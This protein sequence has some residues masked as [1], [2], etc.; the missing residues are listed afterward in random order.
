[1]RLGRVCQW[2]LDMS[3]DLFTYN[4]CRLLR[5]QIEIE[6][7][8]INLSCPKERELGRSVWNDY[9]ILAIR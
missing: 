9:A 5:L 8:R 3:K 4:F 1:M 6:R 2:F 7:I